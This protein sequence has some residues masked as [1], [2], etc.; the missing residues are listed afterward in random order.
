MAMLEYVSDDLK[1]LRDCAILT[2]GFATAC[3]RSEL[4][5]LTVDQVTEVDQGLIVRIE[6]SKTDQEGQGHEIAVPRGIRACPVLALRAWL[7][8]AGI[9][10]GPLFRRLRR[11]GHVTEDPTSPR[12]I[13]TVVKKY[14]ALA[15]LDPDDF[16][17]HSVDASSS[18]STT[19]FPNSTRSRT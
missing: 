12:T 1:G 14:A 5:S 3:R 15:G 17:G 6:R 16:G 10:D 13:A 9:E 11:G 8:A 7:T 2:F 4:A 18:S 19:C